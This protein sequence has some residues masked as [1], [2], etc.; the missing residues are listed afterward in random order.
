MTEQQQH[1]SSSNVPL[2]D[3][4]PEGKYLFETWL[5]DAVQAYRRTSFGDAVAADRERFLAQ[6]VADKAAQWAWD[7]REPEIQAAAPRRLELK[8]DNEFYEVIQLLAEDAKLS[9]LAE[10]A[11]LSKPQLIRKAIGLYARFRVEQ[12]V[13]PPS[14][15]EQALEALEAH[16]GAIEAGVPGYQ[17][18]HIAI[19]RRAIAALPDG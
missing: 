3:T 14:L 8:M 6:L 4:F 9:I 18:V 1:P 11:K 5:A 19:L 16:F 17:P 7:Q 2:L 15:K 10:D 12:K 13:K